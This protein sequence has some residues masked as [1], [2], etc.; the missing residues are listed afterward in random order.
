M[1]PIIEPCEP[2]TPCEPTTPCEPIEP[3][4]PILPCEPM[5]PCEP[6]TPCGPVGPASKKYNF[7]LDVPTVIYKLTPSY[8][9]APSKALVI[10]ELN[11]I[12]PSPGII[13]TSGIILSL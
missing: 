7:F 3:F 12:V 5:E 9:I 8:S 10:L 13:F 4:V 1:E 11:C 2:I 6:I